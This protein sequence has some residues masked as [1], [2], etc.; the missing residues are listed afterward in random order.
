MGI[1]FAA[2]PTRCVV[3][4]DGVAFYE[5]EFVFA[6]LSADE[7]TE[8]LRGRVDERGLLPIPYGPVLIRTSQATILVD[9]GTGPELAKEWGDP[10]GRTLDSLA[11]VG[12]AREE[13]DIVVI[14][15]AHPDHVG[16]L[17]DGGRAPVFARAQHLLSRAEWDFWVEREP[18]GPSAKMVGEVR[19]RLP[20]LRSAG[21]LE[22]VEGATEVVAG[23]QVFP[24]PG[25]TP[26]HLSVALVSEGAR[27]LIAGDV[28]LTEWAFEHP[29]WTAAPEVD[30]QLAIR[31]RREFLARA[32]RE[33][34]VV[35]AYHVGQVG[36]VRR[37]G[38]AFELVEGA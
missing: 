5:P 10:C 4:S 37:K 6:E 23:V 7:R 18:G 31:T 29:D 28:L 35:Q 22:L 27:A 25:H 30:P 32:T 36:R 26:G 20:A 12:V 33:G 3:V 9:A 19:R 17:T 21:L 8:L 11:V 38:E 15:H 16:G 2:G 1:S 24:T 34:S 13:I 14:T